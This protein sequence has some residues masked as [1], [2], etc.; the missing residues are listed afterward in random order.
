MYSVI[1][2]QNKILKLYQYLRTNQPAVCASEENDVVFD[3][4]TF[5]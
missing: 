2:F 5:D 3:G 1:F 4:A